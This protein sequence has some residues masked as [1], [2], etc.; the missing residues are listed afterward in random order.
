[1]IGSATVWRRMLKYWL[2]GLLLLLVNLGVL[3]TYRFLLAGQTQMRSA[4][5]ERLSATLEDLEVHRAALDE[6]IDRAAVNRQR[7]AEFYEQW[8]S[9]EA[10]RLTQV[11]A[12][13]KRMAR[14]AGVKTSGFRYPDEALEELDLVRRSIVFSVEGGYQQLRRFIDALERSEQFL[15]LDEI[16][17]N[18][19]GG[20]SS[21]IRVR[22]KVSTLFL[23]DVGDGEV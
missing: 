19:A 22:I 15:I 16:G 18:E 7:V 5:V 4:R 23:D 12:E 13:V 2:P 6:V 9:S 1:M 10:D 21:D 11:I 17:L 14:S 20:D 3:S 8:L